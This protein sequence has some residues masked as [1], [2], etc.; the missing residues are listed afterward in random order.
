M[1]TGSA[2]PL[3]P[4]FSLQAGKGLWS[5]LAILIANNYIELLDLVIL[6][7]GL[8]WLLKRPGF[9]SVIYLTIYQAI[10]FCY[11]LYRYSHTSA[12]SAWASHLIIAGTSIYLLF[13]G[14]RKIK[15]NYPVQNDKTSIEKIKR[16]LI[17]PKYIVGGIIILILL[18]AIAS[19]IAPF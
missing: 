1:I 17:N 10:N 12:T 4:A 14:Y 11:I 7:A 6:A 2:K 16:V 15:Q 19:A 8:T 13:D 3:V 9:G 5:L 18:K